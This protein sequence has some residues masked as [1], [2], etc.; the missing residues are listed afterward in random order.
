MRAKDL[1]E[2]CTRTELTEQEV[3]EM[4]IKS[5]KT[6]AE[7]MRHEQVNMDKSTEKIESMNRFLAAQINNA[8]LNM[9]YDKIFRPKADPKIITPDK[10]IIIP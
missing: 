8:H 10:K 6:K 4:L 3:L 7:A 2:V 5:D 9:E 1:T